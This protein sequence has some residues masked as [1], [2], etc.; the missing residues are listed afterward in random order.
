MIPS[1]TE[2]IVSNLRALMP[3]VGSQNS[4]ATSDRHIV[5]DEAAHQDASRQRYR[6]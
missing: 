4:S 2:E 6:W 1:L 3:R 5:S